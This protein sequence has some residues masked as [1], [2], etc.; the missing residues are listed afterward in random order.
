MEQ[1]KYIIETLITSI[2]PPQ[3]IDKVK[4]AL[5]LLSK[6]NATVYLVGGAVRD[7]VLGKQTKDI[8]FE[9]HGITLEQLD[10]LLRT[11]GH[12]N[13]I[14]KSFGVLRWEHSAIDWAIPRTDEAG[15]KPIVTLDPS[16]EITQALMRR[17]LTINAMAINMH[18]GE[19]VDPFNGLN[20]LKNKIARSPNPQFFTE[21]PLRFYRVM[22]FVGRFELEPDEALNTVCKSMDISAISQE[23]IHGEFDKLFLYAAMPSRGIR[24]IEHIGRLPEVL[25]ELAATVGVLQ[26]PQWHPE[27]HVFEHIMEVLDAAAALH[28]ENDEQKLTLVSAAL[29]HDLGKPEATY[30]E[31][32]RIRS[33]NHETIGLPR[34]KSLMK[35]ITGNK[36]RIDAVMKL[37]EFHMAPGDYAENSSSAGAYKRLALK[38]APQTSMYE[39]ALLATADLQGRNPE[40][41]TPL[42]HMP[43]VVTKFLQKAEE[44]NIL[45]GPQPAVVTGADLINYVGSSPL[46]GTILHRAYELQ[47]NEGILNKEQLKK[48]VLEE[49]KDQIFKK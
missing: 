43:E 14:G 4:K 38:L 21:D 35:R 5:E 22:Q 34:V 8:D 23:R 26:S 40:K 9:V 45:H 32:E 25:P 42:T 10:Q 11:F 36:K 13:L 29:C 19:L 24:W 28:Y 48:R 44:Y 49:F 47:M 15:R 18:T 3:E 7:I 39:L 37:V 31:K 2:I 41:G 17:D 1:K 46:L 20:D 6:H 12:L 30:I 27:G 16:M 33:T